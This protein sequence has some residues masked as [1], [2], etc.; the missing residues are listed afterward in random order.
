M[1]RT[2]CLLLIFVSFIAMGQ[3]PRKAKWNFNDLDGWVY[4]H[5]DDN[6]EKQ[7]TAEK[8]KL[9][10]FTRKGSADRKKMRTEDRIYTTGRYKWRAYISDIAE[11]DQT[12]IG[13]WLYCDDKHEIDFEVG[14]GK[15]AARAAAGAGPEDM[16]VYMTTQGNPYN[17]KFI[18]ISTG[19]HIFELDLTSVDGKYKVEWIIDGKVQST[20]QQT[21]GPEVAFYIYCSVEN[22]KFLGEHPASQDNYGLFDYVEYVYHE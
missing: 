10:I 17:T 7:C 12:S 5:Q 15:T 14:P 16:I 1:K 18:P 3:S 4:C 13:C 19:W 6:P 22:L 21:F 2:V 8:G 20:V 11:G 9:R